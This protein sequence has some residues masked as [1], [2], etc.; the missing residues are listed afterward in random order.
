MRV[1]MSAQVGDSER[2]SLEPLLVQVFTCAVLS[3]D[4]SSFTLR[5]SSPSLMSSRARLVQLIAAA[6]VFGACLHFFY[7]SVAPDALVAGET[8]PVDA[9]QLKLD[10]RPPPQECPQPVLT[11]PKVDLSKPPVHEPE[12]DEARLDFL[13]GIVAQTKGYYVRD[14]SLGLGWNNVRESLLALICVLIACYRCD[15]SSRHHSCTQRSSTVHWYSRRS[16]TPALASTTCK[17]HVSARQ[18]TLLSVAQLGMRTIRLHGEPRRR[19]RLCVWRSARRRF[20]SR[21]VQGTT[22]ETCP[23]SSRWASVF[24]ST[25]A[26]LAPSRSHDAS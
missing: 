9:I 13:R 23:S 24:P 1:N 16:C 26:L 17:P 20:R 19:H 21:L 11:T 15:T 2:H 6:A 3:F 12:G 25:S 8:A 4:H 7:F 22:G 18:D 5:S 14:W 10:P